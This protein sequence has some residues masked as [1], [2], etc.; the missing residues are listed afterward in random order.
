MTILSMLFLDRGNPEVLT[1][2]LQAT[3]SFW[4]Q[5]QTKQTTYHCFVDPWEAVRRTCACPTGS[6]SGA[7]RPTAAGRR[8]ATGSGPVAWC[9]HQEHHLAVA[10]RVRGRRAGEKAGAAVAASAGPVGVV[11]A[12]AGSAFFLLPTSDNFIEHTED[13]GLTYKHNHIQSRITN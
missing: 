6:P 3:V 8:T 10:A 9:Q 1:I 12:G 4:Q 7:C 13:N 2:A 5:P 11:G